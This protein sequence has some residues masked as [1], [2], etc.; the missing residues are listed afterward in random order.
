MQKKVFYRTVCRTL[1]TGRPV[2]PSVLTGYTPTSVPTYRYLDT[3]HLLAFLGSRAL[4]R[5]SLVKV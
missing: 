3:Y 2:S 1:I 4:L 5:S